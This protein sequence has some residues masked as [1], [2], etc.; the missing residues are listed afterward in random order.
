M[1]VSLD[2]DPPSKI[3]RMHHGT[4]IL[5]HHFKGRIY[6]KALLLE[7]ESATPTS[8]VTTFAADRQALAVSGCL[9]SR[10]CWRYINA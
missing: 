6:L 4:V 2:L 7:G 10:S 3:I 5:D 1:K 9:C 8:F